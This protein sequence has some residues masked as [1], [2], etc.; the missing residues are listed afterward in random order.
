MSAGR[1]GGLCLLAETRIFPGRPEQCREARLWIRGL[2]RP[3]GTVADAV[4]LVTS[5]FFGNAIRHTA[6]GDV[7]GEV[8]V[9]LAG[10]GR[11][12]VYLEVA[13]QGAGTGPVRA[14]LPSPGRTGGRGLYLA[15]A[16]STAWGRHPADGSPGDPGGTGVT[17]PSRGDAPMA[18]WA[19]F[20]GGGRTS[21]CGEPR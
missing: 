9:V 15:E 21:A 12:V 19:L 18:T 11:G 17:G 16:L 2:V 14:Q 13:D 10:L 3:F 6:S 20:L 5:E 7:G 8:T 4:E 1:S